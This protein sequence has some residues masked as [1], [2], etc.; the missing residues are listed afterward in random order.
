MELIGW[1][2]GDDVISSGAKLE[3]A[4]RAVVGDHAGPEDLGEFASGMTAESV[5]LPEAVLR[6]DKALRKHEVIERRG[7]DVGDAMPIALY[8]DRSGEAGE[9]E[10]AVQLGKGLGEGLADPVTAYKETRDAEDDRE[11]DEQ[12]RYAGKNAATLGLQEEMCFVGKRCLGC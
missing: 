4:L 1:E 10:G 2:S 8:G 7:A 9:R 11:R 6:G 5:Q 12:D 3:N